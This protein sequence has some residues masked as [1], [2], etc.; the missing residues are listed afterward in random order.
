MCVCACLVLLRRLQKTGC[1]TAGCNTCQLLLCLCDLSVS[2]GCVE[3][4]LLNIS[5]GQYTRK[6]VL[7][8]ASCVDVMLYCSRNYVDDDDDDCNYDDN[9]CM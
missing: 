5:D 1:W 4:G 2:M 3:T 7:S 9:V 6:C 8:T